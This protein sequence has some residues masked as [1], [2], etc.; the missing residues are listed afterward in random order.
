MK[1][2]DEAKRLRV[3]EEITRELRIHWSR[4]NNTTANATAQKI[5]NKV[6]DAAV[7]AARKRLRGTD[8]VMSWEFDAAI[9]E[10]ITEINK[11]RP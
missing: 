5:I 3:I 8:S 4:K 11:L 1:P 2:T 9:N 6:L 7:E 10:A